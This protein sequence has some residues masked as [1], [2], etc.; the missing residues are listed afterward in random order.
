MSKLILGTLVLTDSKRTKMENGDIILEISRN[1]MKPAP[2]HLIGKDIKEGERIIEPSIECSD[3]CTLEKYELE[4]QLINAICRHTYRAGDQFEVPLNENGD[5]FE[6]DNKT[7]PLKRYT[8]LPEHVLNAYDMV[9]RNYHSTKVFAE[10]VKKECVILTHGDF[11]V[12]LQES[13]TYIRKSDELQVKENRP[14]FTIKELV[15]GYLSDT[16]Y[17]FENNTEE[18]A[19]TETV[20]VEPLVQ[21]I[22]S[23][24]P[25]AQEEPSTKTEEESVITSS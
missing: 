25:T 17:S 16:P 4:H 3:S 5:P 23:H 22:I 7:V 6:K 8:D 19:R 1:W 18:S 24:A 13:G 12:I 9:S 2:R 14:K 11:E 21:K 15:R 20:Q 10:L